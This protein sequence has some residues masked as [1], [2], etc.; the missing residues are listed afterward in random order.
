LF[1][2]KS[3]DEEANRYFGEKINQQNIEEQYRTTMA[4]YPEAMGR[5]LMLYIDAEVGVLKT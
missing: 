4:E 2:K 5:V 3:Y 1:S